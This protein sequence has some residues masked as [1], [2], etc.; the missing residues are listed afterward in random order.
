AELPDRTADREGATDG[1]RRTVEGGKEAVPGG[2]DLAAA[3]P[4]ELAADRGVVCAEEL[5]PAVIAEFHGPLRRADDVGGGNRG[6]NAIGLWRG[7]RP[8]HEL[9][10]LVRKPVDVAGRDHVIVSR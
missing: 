6:E 8:G 1:A 4:L 5:A 10:D 3:E 7:A 9:L 2:I